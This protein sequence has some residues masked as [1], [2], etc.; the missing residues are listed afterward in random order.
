M[1]Q[2]FSGSSVA[3]TTRTERS[4]GGGWMKRLWLA[5]G[6]YAVLA[7]LAWNTLSEQKFRYATVA[8]LAMFAVRSWTWHR[9]QQQQE[10]G[11]ESER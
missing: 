2:F 3:A 10:R 1:H 4:A 5:L 11:D 9:R 7:A 8:I 6:V